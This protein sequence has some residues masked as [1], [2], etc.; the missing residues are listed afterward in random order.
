[1]EQ[2][3]GAE[4]L[5]LSQLNNELRNDGKLVSYQY[6]I[7]V[8]LVT[9]RRGS[10]IYFIKEGEQSFVQG[11]SY[12]IISLLLGWWG[13]PW[14]PIYTIGSIIKNCRGGIDVTQEVQAQLFAM[15]QMGYENGTERVL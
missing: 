14:G 7:S 3:K 4:H 12:T 11:L 10:G 6:A 15:E 5:S 13:I 1:M 9:F 8:I 2:I